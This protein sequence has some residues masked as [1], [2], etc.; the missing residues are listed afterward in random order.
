[1]QYVEIANRTYPLRFTARALLRTQQMSALPF[2]ALFSRGAE[3]AKWLLY[4]A[5]CDH[6]P[7]L[8]FRHAE[9]LFEACLSDIALLYDKLTLA[10]H[11]SGFP[12]EGITQA[13]FDRLLDAA[14]RAGMKNSQR[15]YDLTYHEIV[16]ELDAHLARL[17]RGAA[18]PMT[19]TQ[20]LSVLRNFARRFDHAHA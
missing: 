10:F 12:R 18:A 20:M 15:L 7:S 1:M 9:A 19:D 17:P 13:Q 4:C 2:S 6:K 3:G 11:E 5:L 14:A 16:R 8:A